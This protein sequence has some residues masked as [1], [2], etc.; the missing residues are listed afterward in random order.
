M[1]LGLELLTQLKRYLFSVEPLL[2]ADEFA[3]HKAEV[4]EFEAGAG[5]VLHAKLLS[6][7]QHEGYPHS[8]IEKHWDD[9]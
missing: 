5:P 2:T 1:A 6:E 4:A 7:D 8:Y 9:M 3:K